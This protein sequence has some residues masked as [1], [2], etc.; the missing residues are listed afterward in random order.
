MGAD[1]D[2]DGDP[3]ILGGSDSNG[4]KWWDNATGDGTSWT[5]R[6]V[7]GA[8]TSVK[9]VF[10]ADVDSDGD[11]D[12]LGA[13]E[14]DSIFWWENTAGDGS[15][16]TKRTVNGFF[17]FPESVHA[18]DV[19]GDRDIDVLGAASNDNDVNWW[20]N[21]AGDGGG[22]TEHRVEGSFYGAREVFATDVDG[23]G[24]IDVLGA[25]Y[26]ANEISWWESRDNCPLV[27]NPDQLDTDGDGEGD[28]CDLDD[29]NDGVPDTSDAFPLDPTETSDFDGD[30][31]GDNADTDYDGDGFYTA[32]TIDQR[33]NQFSGW[34]TN[35]GANGN[36]RVLAQTFTAGISGSLIQVKLDVT[37]TVGDLIIEVQDV[38]AGLPNGNVLA[39]LT[40]SLPGPSMRS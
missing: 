8:T 1:L 21:T 3:D 10:A 22:W 12:V 36:Q 34:N 9:S 28:A 24:D 7:D 19:D 35:I 37:C 14:Y 2:G 11:V 29:D 32:T 39:S 30:G 13:A 27:D 23:D 6:N 38:T 31:I 5:G 25:A 16:W 33:V 4:I 17:S 20:E 15:A 18:V 40:G 26:D